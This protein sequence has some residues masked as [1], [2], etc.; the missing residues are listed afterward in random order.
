MVKKTRDRSP[1]NVFVE[2]Q[3]KTSDVTFLV[4]YLLRDETSDAEELSFPLNDSESPFLVPELPDPRGIFD[5]AFRNAFRLCM[6][7]FA[8]SSVPTSLSVSLLVGPTVP[9][10]IVST[11]DIVA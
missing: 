9:L 3:T 7:L 1:L 6:F 8:R 2:T 11:R 10:Q 5:E 4:N